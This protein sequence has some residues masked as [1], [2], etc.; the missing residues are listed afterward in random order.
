[1]EILASIKKEHL[2]MKNEKMIRHQKKLLKLQEYQHI[3][4]VYMIFIMVMLMFAQVI[5]G[6]HLRDGI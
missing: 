2:I 3:Q 5:S 4:H 6:K 1:M